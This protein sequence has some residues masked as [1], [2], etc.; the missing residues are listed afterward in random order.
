MKRRPLQ[1]ISLTTVLRDLAELPE[2][3]FTTLVHEVQGPR[4]FDTER[5]RLTE[6]AKGTGIEADTLSLLLSALNYL[7]SE[8]HSG[9][10]IANLSPDIIEDLLLSLERSDRFLSGD[11]L[12]EVEVQ[13]LKRRLPFVLEK[14][15]STDR[16]RKAERLKSGFLP[17]AT[18]FASFVDLRP[19]LNDRQ[20]L[21][22]ELI[23]IVQFRI[24]TDS[25][26][27]DLRNFVFQMDRSTLR[28]LKE[29]IEKA[30]EKLDNI[31]KTNGIQQLI[32]RIKQ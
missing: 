3:S 19:L 16:F 8:V 9:E 7:Y 12:S 20:D 22:E 14:R 24:R 29:S 26:N 28:H 27:Q 15:S 4:A 10:G 1:Q 5:D 2:S 25:N 13:T 30:E 23:P 31:S 21:I 6:L 11:K 18:N 32:G 17:A